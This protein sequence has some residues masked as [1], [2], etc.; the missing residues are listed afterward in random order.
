MIR[1]FGALWPEVKY[2]ED[3]RE[4]LRKLNDHCAGRLAAEGSEGASVSPVLCRVGHKNVTDRTEN[5][6]YGRDS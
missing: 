4:A 5:Q 3:Y 2:K 1:R 6:R